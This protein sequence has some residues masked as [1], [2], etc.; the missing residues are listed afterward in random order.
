MHAQ[1]FGTFQRICHERG[2]GGDVLEVGAV[3]SA[4]S[5][6]TLEALRGARRKVGINLAGAASYAD[7]RIVEGNANDLRVFAD[8]SFDTVLCNAVLEHDPFFWRSLDEMKR[9]L[10]PAGLLVIGVPA[11]AEL[12]F[13]RPISRLFGLPLIG[14]ML[15]RAVPAAGASTLTL[16]TH[17]FPG[18][19]YRFSSQA[20]REVL[21]HD[22]NDVTVETLMVPPRVVGAGVKR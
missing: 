22:L 17:R 1:V 11:F 8:G 21:L 9:V 2:A 18:D 5:L 16:R 19:Y 3:P 6:L 12:R 10:R 14:R 20:M 13:E 15:R 7:F 4:D